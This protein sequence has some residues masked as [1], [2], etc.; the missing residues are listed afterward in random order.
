MMP[1]RLHL[2]FKTELWCDTLVTENRYVICVSFVPPCWGQRKQAQTGR[3]RAPDSPND[4]NERA[5]LLSL[6]PV[7]RTAI[8]ESLNLRFS[9]RRATAAAEG[10]NSFC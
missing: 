8:L 9:S 4:P 3:D 2:G 10:A 6:L 5:G 7:G 1:W